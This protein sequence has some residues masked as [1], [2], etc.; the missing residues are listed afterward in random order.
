MK[1]KFFN[2]ARRQSLK[3]KDKFRIG[4]VVVDKRKNVLNVGTNDM[5]RTHPKSLNKKYPFIHAELDALVGLDSKD[6]EG[7]AIYVYRETKDGKLAN[8]KPC[9]HCQEL[10]KRYGIKKIYYTTEKG[11]AA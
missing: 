3:S 5:Q 2:L 10:I 4:A 1:V 9:D 6:T 11:F 7:G 8:S